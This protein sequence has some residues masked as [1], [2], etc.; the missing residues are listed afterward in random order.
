M[1]IDT[2]YGFNIHIIQSLYS[3]EIKTGDNLYEELKQLQYE[4]CSED[5]KFELTKV[6][7]KNEFTNILR[8]IELETLNDNYVPIIHIECHG[9]IDGLSFVSDEECSWGELFSLLRPVNIACS[10][11]LLVNLSCCNGD[12]IIRNIE[13]KERAPFRAVIAHIGIAKPENLQ[14]TWTN[15]Y[16]EYFNSEKRNGRGLCELIW[17]TSKEFIYYNQ[18]V[19]FDAY[20]NTAE[21]FPELFDLHVRQDLVAMYKESGTL[22]INPQLYKEWKVKDAK[23]LYNKYKPYFCFDDLRIILEKKYEELKKYE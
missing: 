10:N 20:F 19:I 15:F 21:M 2:L 4:G 23:K 8:E 1:D 5:F 17:D 6:E 7:N 11:L 3:G 9:T 12:A 22:A 13:P 16:R 18:D 14:I